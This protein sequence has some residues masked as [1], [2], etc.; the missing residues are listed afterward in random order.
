[1]M[2]HIIEYFLGF[3]KGVFKFMADY[4]LK[5]SK[6]GYDVLTATDE[7]L[8]FSTKYSLQKIF[9]QGNIIVVGTPSTE[10]IS[11]VAHNLGYKPAFLVWVRDPYTANTPTIL[12]VEANSH[13]YVDENNI[14]FRVFW[15]GGSDQ[16]FLFFYY[17]FIEDGQ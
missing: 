11:S 13:A 16:N 17:I 2:G 3:I 1:M 15:N 5:V 6:D 4:G 8:A 10:V 7:E 9:L 14:Y 12:A